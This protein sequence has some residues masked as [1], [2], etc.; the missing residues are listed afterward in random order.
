MRNATAG[1]VFVALLSAGSLSEN[2]RA[3]QES[4]ADRVLT[5]DLLGNPAID[6]APSPQMSSDYAAWRIAL[7][8]RVPIGFEGAPVGSDD[9]AATRQPIDLAGRRVRDALELVVQTDRRYAWREDRIIVLRPQSAFTDARD[10]LN[11][12]V[13]GIA[14]N[15]VT[16]EEALARVSDMI[17]QGPRPPLQPAHD[18]RRLNVQLSSG[19]IVDV[20]NEI[21]RVHGGLMWSV[22]LETAPAGRM[23]R[24]SFKWFDGHAVSIGRTLPA[25]AVA[26]SRR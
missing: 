6:L 20:L 11:R 4:L 10:P 23:V 14:W 1:V 17:R 13:D 5:P 7:M 24:L 15:G 22:V 21:A 12:T 16:A 8:G 19:Q 2:A 9:R 26:P 25:A 3:T 18:E